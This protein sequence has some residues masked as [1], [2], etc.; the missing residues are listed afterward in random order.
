MQGN[1][2]ALFPDTA[3]QKIRSESEKKHDIFLRWAYVAAKDA[4]DIEH[5]DTEELEKTRGKSL[6]VP[7]YCTKYMDNFKNYCTSGSLEKLEGLLAQF[8]GS[9]ARNCDVKVG[10]LSVKESFPTPSPHLPSEFPTPRPSLSMPVENPTASSSTDYCA[11]NQKKNEM[12]CEKEGFQPE[13]FCTEYK[14]KCPKLET[15]D[16]ETMNSVGEGETETETEKE[17]EKEK[18]DTKTA[19]PA[20][21]LET[22]DEFE[23]HENQKV[24]KVK[25]D[26]EAEAQGSGTDEVTAYC[27]NYIENYNFYCVGDMAPEHEKF[28]DSY[29]KNCP[30]RVS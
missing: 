16:D 15:I 26:E 27:T 10:K 8:C 1:A 11:E 30:D 3:T 22:P 13:S 18:A 25:E 9:Y 7:D 12:E 19:E 17:T 6:S 24:E 20:D 23:K 14:K 21:S 29:K 28:C 2:I 5:V 4:E